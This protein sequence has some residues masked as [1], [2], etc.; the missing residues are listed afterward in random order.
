[1]WVFKK[2]FIYLF[3]FNIFFFKGIYQARVI[4]VNGTSVFPGESG[5]GVILNLVNF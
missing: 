4:A 2:L 1:M 3:T 5:F